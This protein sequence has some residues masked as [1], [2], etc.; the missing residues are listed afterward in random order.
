MEDYD[1]VFGT[2]VFYRGGVSS[3]CHKA[4]TKT[5]AKFDQDFPGWQIY[6]RLCSGENLFDRSV[7]AYFVSLARR[8]SRA[9]TVS[10]REYVGKATRSNEWIR[11]AA[12]DAMDYV[13]FGRYAEGLHERASKLDIAHLTYQKIRDPIALGMRFGVDRWI[14]ELHYQFSQLL[15]DSKITSVENDGIKDSSPIFSDRQMM[16]DPAACASTETDATNVAG[17]Q[18]P[19]AP[20]EENSQHRAS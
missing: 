18:E 5:A 16:P 2:V 8:L 15:Y 3:L 19:P 17:K 14:S 10:G 7:E 13:Y 9:K 12:R 20:I 1:A 6:R 11:Q 4:I